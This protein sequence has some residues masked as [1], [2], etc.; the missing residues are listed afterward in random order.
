MGVIVNEPEE[1]E[2]RVLR[3]KGPLLGEACLSTDGASQGKLA[4]GGG[5]LRTNAGTPIHNFFSYYGEGTNNYV[6]TR[7]LLDGIAY[8][9]LLGIEKMQAYTDSKLVVKWYNR[10]RRIPWRLKHWWE[11]IFEE[12]KHMH[13]SIKH[14]LRELNQAV[15]YLSKQ[16]LER[17]AN[18]AVIIEKHERLRAIIWGNEHGVPYLKGREAFEPSRFRISNPMPW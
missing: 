8:S 16:G 5:L 10:E 2:V 6:E 9:K 11:L 14:V 4:A 13:F 18:G 1:R 3:W 12:T 15:D 17:K 7:A